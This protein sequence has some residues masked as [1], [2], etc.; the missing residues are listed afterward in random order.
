TSSTNLS[1]EEI[2][3]K[4]KEAERFAEEDRKK[5]ER[6]E[7]RNN[8]DSMVYQTE[9][10]LKDLEGKISESEKNKVNEKLEALK[11]ALEGDDIEDIKRKTDELTNEFQAIS[12]KLYE[13]VQYQQND[14]QSD[15]KSDNVEDADYEVVDED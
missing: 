8:A 6:I 11:K 9:K 4:I 3:R 14:G 7:I 13:N 1:E 12:Q 10:I 5:K 2:Q 15:N